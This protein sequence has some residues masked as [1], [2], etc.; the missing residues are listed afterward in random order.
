VPLPSSIV[1][2]TATRTPIVNN[3]FVPIVEIT[4][5]DNANLA[6]RRSHGDRIKTLMNNSDGG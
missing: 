1:A 4:T 2:A 6:D 5:G 3:I